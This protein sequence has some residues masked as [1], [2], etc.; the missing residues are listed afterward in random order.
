MSH[1]TSNPGAHQSQD[2]TTVS[3]WWAGVDVPKFGP[4]PGDM[5]CDACVI[6]AG[7]AGLSVAYQ[8]SKSS[9]FKVVVVDDSQ[10]GD[11][12]TGRT[13]AHLT[14][15]WDDR[16]CDAER[17]LGEEAARQVYHSHST[18]IDVIEA[19]A[20]DEKIDCDFARVD[21]WLFLGEGDE[22]KLLDEELT[23]AHRAGFFT[24]EKRDLAPAMLNNGPCLRFPNQ[25]QFHPMKYLAGLARV[26]TSRGVEIYCGDRINDVQGTDPEKNEP[27]KATSER[28]AVVTASKAIVVCTNT[29][30][31]IND[32]MGV[33]T[34]QAPYRTY[35]IALRIPKGSVPLGLYWDTQDPYHYVR[36]L[37][38]A[39]GAD[40][41]HD[42][43]LVG[44]EDHKTGQAPEGAAPFLKLETWARKRFSNVGEVAFRWSGQVQEPADGVAYIGKAPHKRDGV[45]VATGDSGQGLTHGT[46]AGLLICD[47]ILGKTNPWASLYDPSRKPAGSV[48]EFIKENV[49]VAEQ[50]AKYVTGGEVS[51]EQEIQPGSGAIVR[52]GLKKLA[53]YRDDG[54]QVHKLS[55]K[56]THMGCI[57]S[58]NAVEKT[59]DCPCHGARYD[60]R[61]HVIMGPAIADLSPD[62]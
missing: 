60:A 26:L 18:A 41:D 46:I 2:G 57:V 37:P 15:V 5:T 52:D 47:L 1:S 3:S 56:C 62:L 4:L 35:V 43:L 21:G 7:I 34:K 17:T 38:A 8:L 49:N 30:A 29:P 13:S 27:A 9:S 11:G 24:A 54:G 39:T 40:V 53:V 20:R 28:G 58:W 25:A 36:V 42:L 44:G 51:S 50:Y 23:A 16:F 33:Y 31:P 59:W 22:P 45:F 14:C 32:W 12:Q 55:P 6:G 19:T 48:G 10:V 61:G